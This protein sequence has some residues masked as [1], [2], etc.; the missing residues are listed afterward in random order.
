MHSQPLVEPASNL[1]D[2]VRHVFHD[3]R[4]QLRPGLVDE[5][6]HPIKN[7]IGVAATI[8]EE[9]NDAEDGETQQRH[10]NDTDQQHH[11]PIGARTGRDAP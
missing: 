3:E 11:Q 10:H 7:V 8:G 6:H 9:G 1:S 4:R 5:R 2:V